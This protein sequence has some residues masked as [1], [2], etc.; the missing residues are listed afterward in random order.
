[1]VRTMKLLGIKELSKLTPDLVDTLRDKARS[2][3]KGA[4]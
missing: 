4:K 2:D 1:M 3:S